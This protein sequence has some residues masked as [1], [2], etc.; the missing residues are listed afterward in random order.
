MVGRRS[1]S[2]GLRERRDLLLLLLARLRQGFEGNGKVVYHEW[3]RLPLRT[4]ITPDHRVGSPGVRLT[5]RP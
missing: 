3:E 4:N 5:N 2:G 1:G